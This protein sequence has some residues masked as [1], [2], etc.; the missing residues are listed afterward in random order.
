MRKIKF[1]IGIFLMLVVLNRVGVLTPEFS[2]KVTKWEG[3]VIATV[4]T[5]SSYQYN[6]VAL[7]D[8]SV[9]ELNSAM[10]GDLKDL[11]KYVTVD[12]SGSITVSKDATKEQQESIKNYLETKLSVSVVK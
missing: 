6:G 10:Q 9:S 7:K 3:G 8:Y 11:G 2:E 12:K 1:V 5:A 4:D